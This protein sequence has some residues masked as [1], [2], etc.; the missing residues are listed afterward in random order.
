M[1]AT[2]GDFHFDTDGG[3]VRAVGGRQKCRLPEELL[4][5]PRPTAPSI[6]RAAVAPKKVGIARRIFFQLTNTVVPGTPE[7]RGQRMDGGD[8]VGIELRRRAAV[9][10]GD[11]RAWREWYD[12][13]YDDLRA[14]A[15]WRCAGLE[16]IAEDVVQ[17]TWLT[18]VRRTRDFDPHKGSFRSW[19][20]GIAAN[21]VREH[22]RTA[23]TARQRVVALSGDA[24]ASSGEDAHERA[25]RIATI[26]AALPPRQEQ[27]LRS[28]YLDQ[29]S[30]QEIADAW[31]ETPK[32]IESLLTR[33]RQAFRDAYDAGE[34]NERT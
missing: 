2:D 27:A 32:T 25:V 18:A 29:M 19:L 31:G 11:E 10:A 23:A 1:I 4:Y 26:L 8:R 22:L 34:A 20:F 16:Q 3:R 12:A 24:A 33:A 15:H 13:T 9:L 17:D 30:V 14:Y 5:R 7:W 21:V 28:K 6:G